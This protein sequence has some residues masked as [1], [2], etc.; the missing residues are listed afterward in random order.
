MGAR[1][2]P[3]EDRRDR[4]S[5][6][7]RLRHRPGE[8]DGVARERIEVGRRLQ[9]VAVAAEMV[10]P[11]R[12]D[13]VDQDVRTVLARGVEGGPKCGCG[14]SFSPAVGAGC[15]EQPRLRQRQAATAAALAGAREQRDANHV[16][17][18]NL[19][20]R[21]R[22][23]A[24]PRVRLDRDG[25][26][27]LA[28]I[29]RH[30]D[31]EVAA[32]PVAPVCELGDVERGTGRRRHEVL[33]SGAKRNVQL[34]RFGVGARPIGGRRAVDCRGRPRDR[35]RHPVGRW[36]DEISLVRRTVEVVEVEP[37]PAFDEHPGRNVD[38]VTPKA[39]RQP[40]TT[41][42]QVIDLHRHDLRR[43]VEVGL[44][45]VPGQWPPLERELQRAGRDEVQ[46][47]GGM[48]A[49]APDERPASRPPLVLGVPSVD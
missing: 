44:H 15:R 2:Q 12:V 3:R 30:V 19:R 23:G 21:D 40:Q 34:P 25:G 26:R 28:G 33:D 39:F 38:G 22:G 9:R 27:H 46:I 29:C 20:K 4:G 5:R 45:Q 11:E 41:D 36:V 35:A 37:I 6:P 14:I 8:P 13:Q 17:R 47:Q 42:R 16:I 24:D 18:F 7:G 10:R 48:A 1:V 32:A 49:G 31:V 43:N